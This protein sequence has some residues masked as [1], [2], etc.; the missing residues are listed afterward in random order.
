MRNLLPS[1]HHA[2]AGAATWALVALI[3]SGSASAWQIDATSPI[4]PQLQ[5]AEAAVAR[6]IAIPDGQRTFD[7]TVAA[8]DDVLTRF[9]TDTGM[10]IFM[11]HVS[12]DKDERDHDTATPRIRCRIRAI[13]LRGQEQT[14]NSSAEQVEEHS[15][16]HHG[17]D[18]E[19][20]Q[21]QGAQPDG[22]EAPPASE[23]P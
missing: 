6:I 10:T 16:S 13:R 9:D 17:P 7:H 19:R 4:A 14:S 2:A 22:D 1:I 20:E 12:N 8:L 23:V 21:G 3:G 5:A 11:Q 18:R 15:A